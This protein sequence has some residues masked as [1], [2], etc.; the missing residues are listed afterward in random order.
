M[1][2]NGNAWNN[3]VGAKSVPFQLRRT[4]EQYLEERFP[5]Q[6]ACGVTSLSKSRNVYVRAQPSAHV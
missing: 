2:R 3:V 5:K 6:S 1:Y 4:I